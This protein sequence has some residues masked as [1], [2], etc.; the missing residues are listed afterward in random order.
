MAAP[1]ALSLESPTNS[2]LATD[3]I[4]AVGA[5]RTAV[6][7][8]TVLRMALLPDKTYCEKLRIGR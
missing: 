5:K 8:I 1:A 7:A 6:N 2:P 4:A 3:A